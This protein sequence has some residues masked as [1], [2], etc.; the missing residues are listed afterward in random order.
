MIQSVSETSQGLYE[1][2]KPSTVAKYQSESDFSEKSNTSSLASHS[3]S[4]SSSDSLD[5]F[6]SDEDDDAFRALPQSLP[7]KQKNALKSKTLLARSLVGNLVVTP[8]MKNLLLQSENDDDVSEKDDEKDDEWKGD[9]SKKSIKDL[10]MQFTIT[11]K[12]KRVRVSC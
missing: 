5:P 9:E 8:S 4:S 12:D 6:E 3:S 2:I 7:D 10:Q 1:R 11:K